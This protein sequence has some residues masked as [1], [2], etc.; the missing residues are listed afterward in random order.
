MF[1]FHLCPSSGQTMGVKLLQV[2]F[3]SMSGMSHAS[4]PL[5]TCAT[6]CLLKSPLKVNLRLLLLREGVQNLQIGWAAAPGSAHTLAPLLMCLTEDTVLCC[7]SC[8][9]SSKFF[10]LNRLST[11]TTPLHRAGIL[12]WGK[13]LFSRMSGGLG[14]LFPKGWVPPRAGVPRTQ[15]EELCSLRQVEEGGWC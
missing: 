6:Y 8:S 11:E 13:L 7:S 4:C 9:C 12:C 2:P 1:C 15:Q 3:H 10:W 5:G 14:V